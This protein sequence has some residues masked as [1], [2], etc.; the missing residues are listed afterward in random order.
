MKY[1]KQ[2]KTM[3]IYSKDNSYS[4][5]VNRNTWFE[6]EKDEEPDIYEKCDILMELCDNG[7]LKAVLGKKL[8]ADEVMLVPCYLVDYLY[9]KYEET[10]E[11]EMFQCFIEMTG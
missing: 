1:L 9:K 4:D 8:A 10:L 5:Q 7:Q 11:K 3:M 2:L 6:K